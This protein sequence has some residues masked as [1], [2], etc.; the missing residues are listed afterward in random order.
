MSWRRVV[1]G[2][3]HQPLMVSDQKK[4][5]LSRKNI[6]KET[7]IW[8]NRDAIRWHDE[9]NFSLSSESTSDGTS[10]PETAQKID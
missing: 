6:V 10:D 4:I 8:D 5:L 2:S 1:E 9:C 3:P 7:V